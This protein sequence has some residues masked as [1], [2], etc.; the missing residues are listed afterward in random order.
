MLACLIGTYSKNSA[1]KI[2]SS[3]VRNCMK[4]FQSS[5]REH[6]IRDILVGQQ[7]YAVDIDKRDSSMKCDAILCY[8]RHPK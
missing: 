8:F 2:P 4:N 5:H 3:T 6:I 1:R 7:M